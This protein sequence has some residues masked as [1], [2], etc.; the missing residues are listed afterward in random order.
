MLE[1][2]K[3]EVEAKIYGTVY[4]LRRPNVGEAQDYMFKAKDKDD[5][6]VTK[7]LIKLMDG[8]GLPE[9]VALKMETEHL[10]KLVQELMPSKKK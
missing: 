2:E 1:F 9:K 7:A 8:L 5:A 6:D 10:V 3:T 4:N